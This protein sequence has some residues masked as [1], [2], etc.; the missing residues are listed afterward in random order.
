MKESDKLR[1][2]ADSIDAFRIERDICGV[3][4]GINDRPSVQLLADD[5]MEKFPVG[6]EQK[7]WL[8]PGSDCVAVREIMAYGVCYYALFTKAQLGGENE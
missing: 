7:E 2:I 3:R 6:Y 1:L 5:F 4:T 8:C